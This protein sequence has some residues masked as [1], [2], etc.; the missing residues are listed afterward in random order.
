MSSPWMMLISSPD[1]F[2]L[3]RKYPAKAAAAAKT[4]KAAADKAAAD[5]AATA[6]R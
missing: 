6:N 5:A 2:P 3:S 4:A 1:N